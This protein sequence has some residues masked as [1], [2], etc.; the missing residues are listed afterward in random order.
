MLQD[1]P[2]DG[3]ELA[4]PLT[5][6]GALLA[7]SYVEQTQIVK[8]TNPPA[9]KMRFYPKADGQYY[10]LDSAGVETIMSGLTQAQLDARYVQLTAVD[11]FPV[12]LTKAEGD[13]YYDALGAASAAITA[14][15]AVADP[16]PVYLT[17]VEGDARYAVIPGGGSGGYLTVSS[18]DAT[19][20]KLTGGTLTGSLFFSADNT[21][22]VGASGATRPRDLFLGRNLVVAGTATVTGTTQLT[23]R[24]AVGGT[25]SAG[26]ALRVVPSGGLT[27]G[28]TQYGIYNFS[29]FTG[30]TTAAYGILAGVQTG[31][32]V[33]DI[34]TIYAYQVTSGGT[35]TRAHG[36]YVEN[37]GINGLVTNAYGVYIAA[38]SGASTLNIGL[39]NAG[40]TRLNNHLDW[41]TDNTYDIGASAARRPRDL[42]LGRDLIVGGEIQG[43]SPF[44]INVGSTERAR[45]DTSSTNLQGPTD[46]RLNVNAYYDGSNWTRFDTI[47]AIGHI[48]V[49]AGTLNF[50]NAPA[51]TGAPAWVQRFGIDA[52]GNVSGASI[53]AGAGQIAAGNHTHS[54]L[55][56]TGGGISGRLQVVYTDGAAISYTGGSAG[57][58]E[59]QSTSGAAMIAFHRAGAYAA[60]LGI[61]TDNQWAVGG[62]SMGGNRYVLITDTQSQ[63]LRN[64]VIAWRYENNTSGVLSYYN[65]FYVLAVAN[66][67]WTLPTSS[68][69]AGEMI[70]CKS[71][72]SSNGTIQAPGG[73]VLGTIPGGVSAITIYPG[74]AYTFMSDGGA[75]WMVV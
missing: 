53:G 69:H 30:S 25:P 51:G 65:T 50:Y 71:W 21:Y 47:N 34:Y 40:L 23:G 8:P 46:L 60:Y 52:S 56:S 26:A 14:H 43:Q 38:Q 70:I 75:G 42:Y 74:D 5:L 57:Q 7:P 15:N 27:T 73:C 45:F 29:N 31:G 66:G 16:H 20:L 3:T 37:M 59:V 18:A 33:T 11:P 19:Y 6:P 49:G 4:S 63:T 2:W 41:N 67:V 17:A 24:T 64:K 48:A 61:D 58:L 72:M 32:A 35:T 39:F 55:P 22:D 9:G 44:L 13:G 1:I 68:G 54:Y 28:T 10:K 12:Y 36:L 62:W